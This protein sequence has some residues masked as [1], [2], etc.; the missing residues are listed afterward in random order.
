MPVVISERD[1]KKSNCV[2]FSKI[3]YGVHSTC[4]GNVAV[5][6]NNGWFVFLEFIEDSKMDIEFVSLKRYWKNYPLEFGF[7]ASKRAVEQAVAYWRDPEHNTVKLIFNGSSF[8]RAVWKTL[9][10]IPW[11]QTRTY[12][13]I[14]KAIGRSRAVRAVGGAIGKNPLALIIPCHRVLY[15][16][17]SFGG[18]R[19]GISRKRSI[20]NDEGVLE[21]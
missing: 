16:D 9:L 14:A 11:G 19:W 8:Q 13:D 5:G 15:K 10:K 20:L 12:S 6:V 18:Y 7:S 3:R 2:K 21:K 1:Y 17:G 4:L